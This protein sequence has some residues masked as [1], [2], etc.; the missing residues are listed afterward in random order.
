MD[1]VVPTFLGR[2]MHNARFSAALTI[3]ESLVCE[4]TIL[5]E[6]AI[7]RVHYLLCWANTIGGV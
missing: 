6:C 5:D 7:L 3:G 2:H 4:L 1:V